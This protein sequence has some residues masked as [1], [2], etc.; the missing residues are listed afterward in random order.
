MY[1]L[2]FNV[3][4]QTR[5]YVTAFDAWDCLI[6]T[7]SNWS[8]TSDSESYDRQR[9]NEA[10]RILPALGVHFDASVLG[11]RVRTEA[12]FPRHLW[13]PYEQ[14]P[15]KLHFIHEKAVISDWVS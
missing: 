7:I 4:R 10:T 1:T 15:E 12:T 11:V 13:L 2:R 9:T 3:L 14:V 8:I 5:F 6:V